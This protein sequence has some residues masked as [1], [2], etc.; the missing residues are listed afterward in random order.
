VGS[1]K[2]ERRNL[3]WAQTIGDVGESEFDVA[4]LLRCGLTSGSLYLDL[5]NIHRYDSTAWPDHAGK[6]ERNVAASAAYVKARHARTN[7]GSMKQGL[8]RLLH[9]PRQNPQAFPPGNTATNDIAFLRALTGHTG[10]PPHV[11]AFA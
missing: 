3:A 9:Y 4:D 8:R 10:N 6:I 7:P 2:W 1:G 5:V 11:R